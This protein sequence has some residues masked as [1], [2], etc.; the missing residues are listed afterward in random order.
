MDK[1]I[2]SIIF[3]I[4]LHLKY[5]RYTLIEFKLECP[6]I[7]VNERSNIITNTPFLSIPSNLN[8]LPNESEI[9]FVCCQQKCDNHQIYSHINVLLQSYFAQI[10]TY[11]NHDFCGL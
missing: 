2:Q 6:V 8:M 3:Y 9:P 11:S 1:I 4:W 5:Y 7:T 10:V